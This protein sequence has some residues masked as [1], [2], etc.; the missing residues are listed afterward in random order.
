MLGPRWTDRD[1]H[2]TSRF[3]LPEKGWRNVI[4]PA[5]HDHLVVGR[6][7]LPAIV[8]V[9][10]LGGDGSILGIAPPNEGIVEAARSRGEC[11]NDF[12]R[13][14]LIGEIGQHRRLV[15]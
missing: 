14:H 3:Q 4:D 10:V 15:A 11:W 12:D 5:G 1:Y 9:S 6:I 8:A 7:L 2:D 13:P